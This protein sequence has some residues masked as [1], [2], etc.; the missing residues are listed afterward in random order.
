MLI[1]S[2]LSLWLDSVC[3]PCTFK[4]FPVCP[5]CFLDIVFT[6]YVTASGASHVEFNKGPKMPTLLWSEWALLKRWSAAE[7]ACA[8]AKITSTEKTKK[9]TWNLKRRHGEITQTTRQQAGEN[10]G[11]IYTKKQSGNEKR[12][13]DT[14][15][16]IG[17]NQTRGSKSRHTNVGHG[18]V[19]IKQEVNTE[20]QH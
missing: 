6:S 16:L 4:L 7:M 13:G 17:H 14:A 15:G 9:L 10:K 5:S 3:W 18:S 12:E 19:K 11:L 2:T 1:Q 8:E 20:T